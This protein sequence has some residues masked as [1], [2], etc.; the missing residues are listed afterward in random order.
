MSKKEPLGRGL[1]ALIDAEMGLEVIEID[2]EKIEPNPY[3]PRK[4]FN[5]EKLN[6]LVQSIKT[7]GIIQPLI[8][9][10]GREDKYTLVVGERRWRAAKILGLKTVPVIV[11]EMNNKQIMESAL[12]ENIQ[13]EDL[14]PIELAHA[15]KKLVD[16]FKYTQ[17]ELSE[18]VGRS[19]SSIANVLRLLR[20]PEHMQIAIQ[21]NKITEGHGRALLAIEDEDKREKLFRKMLSEKVTV[22]EAEK[23]VKV[24]KE[25]DITIQDL[26]NRLSSIFQTRVS[27]KGKKK[28]GSIIID[29]YSKEQLDGLINL[30]IGVKG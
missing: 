14:N 7:Q 11:K 6:E 20:L 3:Q 13:R 26:E 23:R 2:P 15:Y 1:S 19:R 16:E 10:K 9:T 25:K 4:Q 18:I 21:E 8:V 12:I 22:R 30:L 28:K 24:R 5:Q 17:E 27:I 29:Y